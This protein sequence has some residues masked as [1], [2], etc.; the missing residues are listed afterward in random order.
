MVVVAIA[1]VSVSTPFMHSGLRVAA[2][3]VAPFLGC[4]FEALE[5]MIAGPPCIAQMLDLERLS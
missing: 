3:G 5:K 1:F 4:C 2:A